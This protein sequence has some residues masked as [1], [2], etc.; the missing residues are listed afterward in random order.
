MPDLQ[1]TAFVVHG[2]LAHGPYLSVGDRGNA[3]YR[4]VQRLA[5]K[6]GLEVGDI[7]K[8]HRYHSQFVSSSYV[9]RFRLPASGWLVVPTFH[10]V[11]TAYESDPWP[12]RQGDV[13][14]RV[15]VALRGLLDVH[16][17]VPDRLLRR[18]VGV[19]DDELVGIASYC[20]RGTKSVG[21]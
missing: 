16:R 11:E 21:L 20:G 19:R 15:P 7:F 13:L 18:R 17:V 4:Q 5:Q 1:A 14:V 9:Y 12:L 10:G 6:S 3:R 2:R 8:R